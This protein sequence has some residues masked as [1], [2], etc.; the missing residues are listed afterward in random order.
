MR[1]VLVITAISHRLF[2]QVHFYFNSDFNGNDLLVR[3][4]SFHILLLLL[5]LLLLCAYCLCLHSM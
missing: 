3:N 1:E 4:G 5:L 2:V